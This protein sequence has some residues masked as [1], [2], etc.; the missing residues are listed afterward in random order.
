VI[1]RLRTGLRDCARNSEPPQARFLLGRF[2]R[3][4]SAALP[5]CCMGSVWLA[6]GTADVVA[7]PGLALSES[8]EGWGCEVPPFAKCAK[9]GSSLRWPAR[10]TSAGAEARFLLGRFTRRLSAA[11]PRCCVGSVRLACA[12]TDVVAFLGL[13]LS[14]SSEG[15]GCGIFRRVR[16][17]W[18]TLRG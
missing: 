4:L 9:D 13:A 5:R 8:S 6:C 18:G 17:G 1:S 12:T 14:E 3:R 10:T 16:E 7:F 2:T 11:L 15:W